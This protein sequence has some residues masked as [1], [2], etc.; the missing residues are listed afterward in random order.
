MI[1]L[2]RIIDKS[3]LFLFVFITFIIWSGFSLFS[4]QSYNDWRLVQIIILLILNIYYFF[5]PKKSINYFSNISILFYLFLLF[6]LL[7]SLQSIHLSRSLRDWSLYAC[8]FSSIFSLAYIIKKNKKLA[9]YIFIVI[10]C[11]PLLFII[12]FIYQILFYYLL[13]INDKAPIGDIWLGQFG[14]PRIFGD[15]ALPISFMLFSIFIT[16][17]NYKKYLGLL[18]VF[19]IMLIFFCGGRGLLISLISTLVFCYYLTP[20]IRKEILYFL[21]FLS[22]G[23]IL[24]SILG[25][26]LESSYQSI[27]FRKDS[28]GRSEIINYISSH[29]MNNLLL[30]ISPAQFYLEG[31]VFN[32]RVSHPHNLF[33][34]ILMEWGLIAFILFI[35]LLLTLFTKVLGKASEETSS[36]NSFI[37][38]SVFS[39][40]INCNF[41]GAHIY[42]SSQIYGLFLI[43][44]LVSIYF[45][46][47]TSQANYKSVLSSKLTHCFFFILQL[48]VCLILIITTFMSLGCGS[49]ESTSK[50]GLGGPRFWLYDSPHSDLICPQSKTFFDK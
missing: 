45:I 21:L 10:S 20:K 18:L 8:I 40:I 42:P 13:D 25:Y 32:I 39:F 22:L 50:L 5:I 38:L 24:N 26:L 33:L 43:S 6:G 2:Q 14:H 30:G 29:I 23:F 11:M 47:D 16:T 41:N 1:F 27:T 31:V 9:L 4:S 34:Q 36:F 7:S 37:F 3:I 48:I 46:Q 12:E 15:T 49:S 17:Q 28:S 19:F 44:W 35:T